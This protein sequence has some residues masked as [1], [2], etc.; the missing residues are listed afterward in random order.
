[1]REDD[2]LAREGSSH[3]FRIGREKHGA[4]R[5]VDVL[6]GEK[7]G[8]TRLSY[9]NEVEIS[10]NTEVHFYRITFDCVI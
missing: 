4:P 1:M 2:R 3:P 10:V 6:V 8:P 7:C 5:V 9:L